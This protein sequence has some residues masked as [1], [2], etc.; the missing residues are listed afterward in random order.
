M[1]YLNKQNFPKDRV[2]YVKNK[3]RTFATYNIINSA[4]NFCGEDDVQVRL[5][6]DDVLIGR[7]VFS[8]INSFYQRNPDYYVVY[9]TFKSSMF[10]YGMG[11]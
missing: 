5:D 2:T 11:N 7:N 10:T 6:G 3:E 1:Q 8:L 4:F 9:T